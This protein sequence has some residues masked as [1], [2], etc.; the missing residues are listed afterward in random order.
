MGVL[1]LL[2]SLNG[3]EKYWRLVR[4]GTEYRGRISKVLRLGA[5]EEKVTLVVFALNNSLTSTP[6]SK[7]SLDWRNMTTYEPLRITLYQLTKR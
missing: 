4:F 1:K 3:I 2:I 5:R 6:L 7:E